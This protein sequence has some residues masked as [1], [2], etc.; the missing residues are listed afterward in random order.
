MTYRAGA[1]QSWEIRQSLFHQNVLSQDSPKFN[2]VKVSR[3]TVNANG[4]LS[5]LKVEIRV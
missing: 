5:N 3:C 4:M 2:N 1:L